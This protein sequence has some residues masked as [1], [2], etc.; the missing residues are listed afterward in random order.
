MA[1]KF[2]PKSI[3]G[4]TLLYVERQYLTKRLWA[5]HQKKMRRLKDVESSMLDSV[6]RV[7]EGN[8]YGNVMFRKQ[9]IR[10]SRERRRSKIGRTQSA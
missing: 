4:R 8:D 5:K 10:C 3:C 6:E 9:V 1:S 2:K 7:M